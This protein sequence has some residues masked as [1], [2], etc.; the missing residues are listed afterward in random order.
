MPT[1]Y[2]YREFV[3]EGGLISYGVNLHQSYRR[4][5]Y[6]IDRILKGERP[7]DLP[8]EFPTKLELVIN[9]VTAK[10]LGLDV[11][12]RLRVLADEIIE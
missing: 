8:F 5:A 3:E 9:L 4:T 10:A 6:D 1:V 2:S 7:A 12:K 11:P